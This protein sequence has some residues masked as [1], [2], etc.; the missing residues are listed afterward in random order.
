MSYNLILLGPPGAG[1]G[2]Q[3]KVLTERFGIPQI[4]TGDILR[5]AVKNQTSFGVRAKAFMD[6][7]AL[8]PDDL[9]IDIIRE[10]L[11]MA[12]SA[13]G[14]ILDGFPRTVAQADV[15]S[16]MLSDNAKAID[17]VISIT[18]DN[19]EL[20]QRVIGRLTCK[21]CGRGYHLKF[22][23]PAAEGKCNVCG[24]DLYQRDDDKEETMRARLAAYASQTA[25][26]IEY[27]TKLGLV[28]PVD[29][30]G[31]IQEISNTLI[32]VVEG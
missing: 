6:Q 13:H 23:P 17:H 4:S 1:K 22:D 27:Y 25:P 28:R 24:A 7:G 16:K 20:I 14:F 10:R 5:V 11:S 26:L 9:V 15:L 18:V 30:L 3:A 29:G 21:G 31:A 19:D 32:R 2:T 8:V 12:D